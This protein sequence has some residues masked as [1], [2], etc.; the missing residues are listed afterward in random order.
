MRGEEPCAPQGAQRRRHPGPQAA[1]P[2][3]SSSW[4]GPRPLSGGG[5]CAVCP[6]LGGARPAPLSLASCP[7]GVFNP[8]SEDP[9]PGQLKKQLVLRIISGQQLPKPRDSML[10]DRGE[11]GGPP[12][13][14]RGRPSARRARCHLPCP[15]IIDPFVEVEVIGLPVDCG[16]EQTRVVDDNGEA[17]SGPP[18]PRAQGHVAAATLAEQPVRAGKGARATPHAPA[19]CLGHAPQGQPPAPRHCSPW[20]GCQQGWGRRQDGAWAWGASGPEPGA[21][22]HPLRR[23]PGFNPMWEETLV[24]MVHMPEL[25]LVRF[26]V[27]DH[28]PIGRDF[29][30]Q[31]TLALSSMMPG[32]LGAPAESSVPA[33]QPRGPWQGG[34]SAGGGP[35]PWAL[36]VQGGVSGGRA[37]RKGRRSLWARALLGGFLEA[38]ES[39]G[40]GLWV[41][42]RA[43]RPLSSVGG[44]GEP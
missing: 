15:Q 6:A 23:P 28:D 33:G 24:F 19:H 20:P 5:G 39:P 9:L 1:S 40:P 7:P 29:I 43:L 22:R 17:A 30:G 11:V 35:R 21:R 18:C 2:P 34:A 27:W 26:L 42:L 38:E 32:G 14:G 12:G 3:P 36:C 41:M 8:N 25:A 13:H 37:P 16:K 31:R 4:A 10:G 44:W